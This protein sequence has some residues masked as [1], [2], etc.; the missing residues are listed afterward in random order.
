MSNT[1]WN[2]KRWLAE[3]LTTMLAYVVRKTRNH[4]LRRYLIESVFER[5]FAWRTLEVTSRTAF[6]SAMRLTLPDSVQ[7][8]ILMTGLWEPTISALVSNALRP[9]DVFIDIG[10]N[11]GYYT[12]LASS[13]VGRS[14]RVYAFEASPSIFARLQENVTLNHCA[15]TV[16]QNVAISNVRG[17]CAIWQAPK[18]NLGHSTIIDAVAHLEGHKHEAFVPCDCV[19]SLVPLRDLLSARFVKIDVEGAERL[20]VEGI[21]SHLT[22]FS[23]RTEWLIELSPEFSPGGAADISWVF[24]VFVAAGYHAYR[25]ENKYQPL[26]EAS[27]HIGERITRLYVGPTERLNDVLFTKSRHRDNPFSEVGSIL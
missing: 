24:D 8:R 20:A 3:K 25:I 22:N 11:I 26:S 18:G 16:I 7:T 27:M 23:H 12:L 6:G 17:T 14:G 13:M 1:Q 19:D 15:N 5:Y 2:P 4:T 10:A 21:Q 9:G